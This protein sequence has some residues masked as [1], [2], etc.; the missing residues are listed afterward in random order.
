MRSSLDRTVA[1]MLAVAEDKNAPIQQR[2]RAGD[3]VRQLLKIKPVPRKRNPELAKILRQMAKPK[4]AKP[5]N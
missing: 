1:A 2:T 3:V 5:S 4:L